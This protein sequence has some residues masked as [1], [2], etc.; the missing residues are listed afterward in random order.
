MASSKVTV[1]KAYLDTLLRKAQFH[2]DGVDYS[3]PVHVPTVTISKSD[4]DILLKASREYANLQRNLFRGGV[5]PE[6]LAVLVNDD[7][8]TGLN[9]GTTAHSTLDD[10]TD[11]DSFFRQSSDSVAPGINGNGQ[12]Y[13]YGRNANYAPRGGNGQN[14]GT[15]GHNGTNGYSNG[16][17]DHS[18]NDDYGSSPDGV[19]GFYDGIPN[20]DSQPRSQRQQFDK[21]AKRTILL[22]NL[23]DG[24][25]HADITEVVRGGILLD[26]YV[27]ANDRNAS[28]S[29][30]EESAAQEFFRYVKRH[31]LYIRG[32]RVEIR[33]NE[34]QFILPGHVA[35]KI[36]IGATRNL[37][38]QNYNPKH[39]EEVI[40]DDLEH[41]HNLTVIKVEFRGKNC[42]IS[43]NSVHNSMFARTCM[44]S[45]ATYKGSKIEWDKDECAGPLERPYQSREKLIVNKKKENTPLKNRFEL[46]NL[47][48]NDGEEDSTEDDELDHSGISL[49]S[50]VLVPSPRR[51]R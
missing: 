5:T 35:N 34:R 20:N 51:Y 43:T 27:R 49:P 38:I 31:D 11:S 44:M 8:G 26:L 50:E 12:D 32:K 25:T 37:V 33:W 39:T 13:T 36:S 9:G 42:Y 18:H 16:F 6:T 19:D 28:V 47:D 10:P 2:T 14:N 15:T 46:L 4:H 24:T 7:T 30:L 29:F 45:R 1:E 21:F 48:D 17:N 23:P 40:R 3:A 22:S 41:I